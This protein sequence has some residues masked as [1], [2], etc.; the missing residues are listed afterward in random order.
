LTTWLYGAQKKSIDTFI[1]YFIREKKP[2]NDFNRAFLIV[3]PTIQNNVIQFLAKTIR[4][5][6]YCK[7]VGY[8]VDI[9]DKKT[10]KSVQMIVYIDGP[11]GVCAPFELQILTPQVLASEYF[12]H[13]HSDYERERLDLD[14]PDK[15]EKARP[16]WEFLLNKNHIE[17]HEVVKLVKETLGIKEEKVG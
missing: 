7:D 2:I 1:K 12:Q 3:E 10:W 4:E 5:D 6:L 16:I 17:S 11:D 9:T 14:K 13:T 15:I 8:Y